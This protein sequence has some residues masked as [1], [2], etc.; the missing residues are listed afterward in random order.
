LSVK[1]DAARLLDAFK[2]MLE[3]K[4][5]GVAVVNDKGQITGNISV[6]D[7]QV[8]SNSISFIHSF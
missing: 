6:T 1:E 3:Q 8:K 4:V 2:I 7:L 5:S